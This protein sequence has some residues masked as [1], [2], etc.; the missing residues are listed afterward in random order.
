MPRCER[1][2][3]GLG[4]KAIWQPAVDAARSSICIELPAVEVICDHATAD[5]LINPTCLHASVRST[6]VIPIVTSASTSLSTAYR[7]CLVSYL[8]TPELPLHAV[9]YTLVAYQLQVCLS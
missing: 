9:L 3:A 4:G 7:L 6:S 2:S 5:R 1:T 8:A